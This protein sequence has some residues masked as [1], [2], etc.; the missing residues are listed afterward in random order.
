M[1]RGV[2]PVP[3]SATGVHWKLLDAILDEVSA[4]YDLVTVAEYLRRYREA[5]N[6]A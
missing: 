2:L 1:R 5:T 4:D 6:S 3:A